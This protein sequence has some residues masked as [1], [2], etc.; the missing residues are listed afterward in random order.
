MKKNYNSK[1]T[2][3]HSTYTVQFIWNEHVQADM[4]NM[5]IVRCFTTFM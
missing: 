5:E 2:F 3:G 4:Q 1:I